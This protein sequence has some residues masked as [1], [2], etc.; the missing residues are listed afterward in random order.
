MCV[1]CNLY[2]AFNN[3]FNK[4]SVNIDKLGLFLGILFGPT[5]NKPHLCSA[6][7]LYQSNRFSFYTI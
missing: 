2:I 5:K 1:I 3:N 4:Q 7:Q 6:I